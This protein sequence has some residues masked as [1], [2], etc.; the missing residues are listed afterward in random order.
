MLIIFLMFVLGLGCGIVL[1]TWWIGEK[2]EKQVKKLQQDRNEMIDRQV[3]LQ[4][5]C[6]N[7]E[8]ACDH[9]ATNLQMLCDDYKI[10]NIPLPVTARIIQARSFPQSLYS[11]SVIDPYKCTPD[12]IKPKVEVI[13]DPVKDTKEN[14]K[15]KLEVIGEL[16]NV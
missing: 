6:Y 3:A 13:P 14:Q 11:V 9:Y 16:F 7:I 5:H 1:G 10:R 15:K 12:L 8:K 2:Q 4:K